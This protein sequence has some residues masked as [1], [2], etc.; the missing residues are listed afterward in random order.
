[1]MADSFL[2]LPNSDL[3]ALPSRH[4][5]GDTR[6]SHKHTYTLC[7]GILSVHVCVSVCVECA[8]TF[9]Q[10]TPSS[11]SAPSIKTGDVAD[12]THSISF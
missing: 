6:R 7:A 2:I 10:S 9:L 1:M 5:L 3:M 8:P 4:N 12:E 11:T